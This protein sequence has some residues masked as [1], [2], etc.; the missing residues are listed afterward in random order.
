MKPAARDKQ[1]RIKYRDTRAKEKEKTR[2]YIAATL[3]NAAALAAVFLIIALTGCNEISDI[4][5]VVAPTEEEWAW[6]G[7]VLV[8]LESGGVAKGKFTMFIMPGTY[9]DPD[10]PQP[11]EFDDATSGDY[12]DGYIEGMAWILD[13]G[14]DGFATDS[15]IMQFSDDFGM[16]YPLSDN[17]VSDLTEYQQGALDAFRYMVKN[18]P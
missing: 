7:E 2:W 6:E 15:C 18:W 4:L 12:S 5:V 14:Y 11:P 3:Q 9:P 13:W 8:G 16:P 1:D 10:I 17:D